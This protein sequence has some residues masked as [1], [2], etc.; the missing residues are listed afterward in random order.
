M[1]CCSKRNRGLFKS[2]PKANI[3]APPTAIVAAPSPRGRIIAEAPLL[4]ASPGPGPSLTSVGSRVCKACGSS[5]VVQYKFSERLRRY[6]KTA[7]CSTC[8]KEVS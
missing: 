8:R 7:W 6:Y 1:G 3:P 2:L 4:R 5:V